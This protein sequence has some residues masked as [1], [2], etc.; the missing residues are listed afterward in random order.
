M[1]EFSFAPSIICIA[2]PTTDACNSLPFPQA[3]HPTISGDDMIQQDSRAVLVVYGL[4]NCLFALSL[5]STSS[6]QEPEHRTDRPDAETDTEPGLGVS[7]VVDCFK[8]TG[9]DIDGVPS[10]LRYQ[11]QRSYL[12][13][14]HRGGAQVGFPENC[15]ATF[16]HSLEHGCTMLE[17]DPRLTRDGAIVLHHDKTLDRTTS[18]TGRLSDRTLAELKELTLTDLNGDPTKHKMPTLGEAIQW[19]RDKTVLVLDQKDVPLEQR[20]AAIGDHN[21]EGFV[22]LIIS[23]LEDAQQVHAS[24]DKIMMEIMVPN[25]ERVAAIDESGVPWRNLIAFVGHQ[26]PTDQALVQAIHDRGAMC[27]AGTSRNLDRVLSAE[28][29]SV[30]APH[31]EYRELLKFGIDVIET[32]LPVQVHAVLRSH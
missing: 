11:P 23:K 18:G 20:I 5:L 3:S 24:N 19:A 16:E 22:M 28:S 29:S 2:S 7:E 9:D 13:S 21:A 25:L 32:D 14:A 4:V 26:P 12:L 10:W 31:D 8:G 30:K 6:S 17:V 15:I 1:A 27:M